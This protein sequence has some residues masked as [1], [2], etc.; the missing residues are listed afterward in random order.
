MQPCSLVLLSLILLFPSQSSKEHD[1]GW[2]RGQLYHPA[3]DLTGWDGWLIL[4]QLEILESAEMGIMLTRLGQKIP[5]MG[6]GTI[7]WPR[8]LDSSIRRKWAAHKHSAPLLPNVD[9]SDQLPQVPAFMASTTMNSSLELWTQINP[10][11]FSCLSQFITDMT[12]V[13]QCWD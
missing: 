9:A 13:H 5:L 7:P 4:Y 11:P 3:A 2:L 1:Y 12:D 10:L 8:T 6:G